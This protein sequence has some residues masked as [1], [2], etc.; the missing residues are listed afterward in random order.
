MSK[1]DYRKQ[2]L[3]GSTCFIDKF[4]FPDLFSMVLVHLREIKQYCH[5]R[6]CSNTTVVNHNWLAGTFGTLALFKFT[7]RCIAGGVDKPD[8]LAAEALK[9]LDMRKI[10]DYE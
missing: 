6:R 5:K 2:A 10:Y 9:V 1:A 7:L 8:K 3:A 4:A